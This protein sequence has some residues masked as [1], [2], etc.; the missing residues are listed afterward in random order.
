MRAS[1]SS[2]QRPTAP[3][4][5]RSP[6]ISFLVQWFSVSP[7]VSGFPCA[8]ILCDLVIMPAGQRVL[9]L[10]QVNVPC[11]RSQSQEIAELELGVCLTLKLVLLG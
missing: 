2:A 5:F 8:L 7:G 6:V 11:S 10:Y 1:V 9:R 3:S 4:C